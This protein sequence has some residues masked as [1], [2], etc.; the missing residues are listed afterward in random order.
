M[1]LSKLSDFED[2]ITGAKILGCGGGGEESLAIARAKKILEQGLKVKVIDPKDMPDD[3]LLCVAG[4]VGGRA[5]PECMEIVKHLPVIDERPVLTATKLLEAFL[6]EKLHTLISTEIGAGNFLAP[7]YISAIMG[8]NILDG[9]LA[10]R[11]KPEI[12]ISASNVIGIPIT[13]LAIVSAFGDKMILKDAPNDQRAEAIARQMAVISGGVVGVAR[14]PAH[15]GDYKKAAIPNTITKSKTLGAE[16]RRARESGRNPIKPLLQAINGKILFEG[17]VKAFLAEDKDGFVIGELLLEGKKNEE[18]KV[19]FKNEF[20]ITWKEK[21]RF[22][23]SPD[24]ICIV[25]QKTG[26]GLTPWAEDF[27]KGREVIVVGGPNAPLWRTKRGIEIFG[28]RHFG[29]DFDYQPIEE[30]TNNS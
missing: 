30:L 24:L 21:Q 2:L 20:L 15:W 25:D 9:D 28:P 7:I 10:G 17:K 23:T 11:A 29:F 22:V 18:F 12:S 6:G 5:S 19:W 26:E 14:C 3:A 1:E 13:P 4:M 16:I 27:S 8:I